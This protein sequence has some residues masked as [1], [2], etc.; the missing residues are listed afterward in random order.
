MTFTAI[1]HAVID[2]HFQKCPQSNRLTRVAQWNGATSVYNPQTGRLHV[3]KDDRR[4]SAYQHLV[5]ESTASTCSTV[6]ASH[7][8]KLW[9]IRRTLTARELA[10]V[11]GFPEWFLVPD[12]STASTVHRLFG[13]AVC[14]PVAEYAC[15]QIAGTDPPPAMR[16]IDMCSGIG[17]F[18]CAVT[19]TFKNARC[20]GF[21]EIKA[22]AIACYLK[23]FPATPAL[24]P[25]ETAVWPQA[26]LVCAGFPCQPFSRSQHGYNVE[27]HPFYSFFEQ[28]CRCVRESGASRLIFENVSSLKTTG[29]DVFE[30]LMN[31]LNEMGFS[32]QFA[33]LNAADFGVPQTR[34]RLFIVGMRGEAPPPL[35]SGTHSPK[36]TLFDILQSESPIVRH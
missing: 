36:A 3:H 10:R 9:D 17:G 24:G 2:T 22:S 6:V 16:F 27:K 26:D 4:K 13:N 28:V 30:T 35:K 25:A 14:V 11:Q 1:H 23:N 19:Q 20:V 7:V 33:V 8:V 34:K 21:S 31:R 15:Q 29:K 18:H 5:F 32:V 12:T